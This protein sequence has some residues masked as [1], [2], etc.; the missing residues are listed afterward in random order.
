M[1]FFAP[2]S[3]SRVRLIATAGFLLTSLFMPAKSRAYVLTGASWPSNGT[4]T[5][6]MALGNAGR[7]LSDGNT[8]WDIAAKPAGDAWNQSVQ[9]VRLVMSPNPSAPIS[10]GDGVN[11]VAFAS[12][13]FG[14]SFGSNTLAITG[15]ATRSGVTV[16]ADILFNNHLTW[17]S[18]RGAVRFGGTGSAIGEIRR[19]L[20]HELGHALGLNHPDTAGQHVTAIMNSI[21]SSVELPATDDINGAQHLYGAPTSSPTPT[22]TPTPSPTPRP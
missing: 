12:S 5:F 11:T 20:I 1:K 9:R 18:Y 6:Q 19:V 7:T 8:S 2:F 17:D 10:Q 4:V 16:E 15:W 14:N 22:P 3:S 21:M 13:F